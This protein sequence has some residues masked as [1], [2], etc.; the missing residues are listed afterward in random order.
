[1]N[2]AI[3]S[4]QTELDFPYWNY[5]ALQLVLTAELPAEN[6]K[7]LLKLACKAAHVFKNGSKVSLAEMP[8]YKLN[9]KDYTAQNQ[10][11]F[12]R[13]ALREE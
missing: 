10:C 4:A 7:E 2:G 6:D 12:R 11:G 5:R 8:D 1:M 3:T 9:L 13:P